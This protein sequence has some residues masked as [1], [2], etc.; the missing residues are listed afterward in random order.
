MP[1]GVYEKEK[2]T[3]IPS[4]LLS[5]VLLVTPV[6]AADT[7]Q[8]A[9]KASAATIGGGT[10]GYIATDLAGLTAV[11]AVGEGAC[12]GL[13]AGPVGAVGGALLGLAVYGVYRVFSK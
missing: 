7:K 11:G 2:M 3:I 5:L 1:P 13:S 8:E 12:V 9:I 6:S 4:I 10:I